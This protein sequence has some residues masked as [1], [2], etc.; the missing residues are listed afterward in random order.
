MV[1]DDGGD[2]GQWRQSGEGL[3]KRKEM[4]KKKGKI[5]DSFVNYIL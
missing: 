3:K 1:V 2:S 4:V 5:D